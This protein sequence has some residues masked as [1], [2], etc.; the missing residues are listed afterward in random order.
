MKTIKPLSILLLFILLS[1]CALKYLSHKGYTYIGYFDYDELY[2]K[3]KVKVTSLSTFES[4]KFDA[5]GEISMDFDPSL[6]N[7]EDY[8]KLPEDEKKNYTNIKAKE[9]NSIPLY[10][11]NITEEYCMDNFMKVVKSKGANGILK[12]KQE[13]IERGITVISENSPGGVEIGVSLNY[14]G[15]LVKIKD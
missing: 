10:L 4:L 13:R 6:L 3:Y 7:K 1:A 8:N 9:P 12:F 14:S 5:L 11:E 15:I 2:Q